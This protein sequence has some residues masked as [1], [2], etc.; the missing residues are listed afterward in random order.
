MIA[1]F[2]IKLIKTL[3]FVPRHVVAQSQLNIQY[4]PVQWY[5]GVSNAVCYCVVA[6]SESKTILDS[7]VLQYV[8]S[9]LY[10]TQKRNMNR[11]TY[12]RESGILSH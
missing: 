11:N 9:V 12:V 3:H 7:L 5:N 2:V 10:M 4:C 6:T 1:F 8:S